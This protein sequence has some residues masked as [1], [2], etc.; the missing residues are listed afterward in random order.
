MQSI[1]RRLKNDR[2]KNGWVL[3]LLTLRML[4]SQRGLQVLHANEQFLPFLEEFL[5]RDDD[6]QGK[7]FQQEKQQLQEVLRGVK[8]G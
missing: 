2:Y 5:G 1:F 3:D 8:A 6:T 7:I 4:L